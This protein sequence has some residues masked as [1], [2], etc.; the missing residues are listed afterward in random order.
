[1]RIAL[2]ADTHLSARSPECIA[3]W[4]AA[5]R[6]V[7][8]L[9][10]DITIHLGDITLSGQSHPDELDLAVGL[11]RQWPTPI[12]CVPG[13]HDVGDASGESPFDHALLTSYVD[14]F[15]PDH[16]ALRANDWLLIGVNAQLMGSGTAQEHAQWRWIESQAILAGPQANTVLFLHRPV[17]RPSS[18]ETARRGRYVSQVARDRLL[19]GPLRQSLRMVVTGHTHQYLDVSDDGVRHV[20]VPSSAF[21]LPDQMQPRL[22]EKVVGLGLLTLGAGPAAFDL[23][24][25]DGMVRHTVSNLN[26][27][28]ELASKQS[29]AEIH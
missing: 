23:W 17:L 4:Y 27:Y 3:N 18:S 11:V 26:V 16:W 2:I 12:H 13:N 5:R 6:A 20:W 24:C 9:A 8:R 10:P 19:Q 28:R 21:V 1:M 29:T 22:G 14:R 25:T 7:G 15:G